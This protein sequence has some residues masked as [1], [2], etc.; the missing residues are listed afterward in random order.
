MV[1]RYLTSSV[2]VFIAAEK[3]LADT[4]DSLERAMMTLKNNLGLLQ[5]GR[6]KQ[7]ILAL[8]DQEFTYLADLNIFCKH[9]Y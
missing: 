7:A 6:V 4:V 1:G 9:E 2:E 3:E 8:H 5:T